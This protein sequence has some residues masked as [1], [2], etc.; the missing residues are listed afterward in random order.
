MARIKSG[1]D[2]L[3]NDPNDSGPDQGTPEEIAAFKAK[4]TSTTTAA[5]TTAPTTEKTPGTPD[6]GKLNDWLMNNQM[7]YGAGGGSMNEQAGP[8]GPEV[9][10][11][12][13]AANGYSEPGQAQTPQQTQ[14]QWGA[15][16]VPTA[17]PQGG[18]SFME[19]VD[20]GKM[21]D[22]NHTTPK[23][24][25]ARIL[26]SGGSLADAAK[27]IGATVLG[28]DTM[29]LATGETIDTRRDIEG[30]NQLQWLVTNDP[31]D[32][33]WG[34]P[35]AGAAGAAS[36]SLGSGSG[37]AGKLMDYIMGKAGQ[38]L[39][40][41]SKDPLIA[42]QVNAYGAAS[43]RASNDY[44]R[45]A[46]ERGGPVNNLNQEARMLAEKRGQGLGQFTGQL[47][48]QE[49]TTR[50]NEIMQAL[51]LGAAY[52]TDQQRLAL[53]RQ[54]ADMDNALAYARL[55]QSAYEFDSNDE[56]RRSP[57]AN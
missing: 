23:Y 5:P 17:M 30:A 37:P 35:A 33:N 15:N 52:M 47:M 34:K 26:A 41:N 44:L 32:P 18:Y 21:N 56:F 28:P 12:G 43:Q 1:P 19:G 27:A 8:A 48:Q 54:L 25:A 42:K 13:T 6:T 45:Q 2:G 16:G 14:S 3:Y 4:Q 24:V 50:R 55:G 49:L 11:F 9:N 53:Q 40:I 31:N 10:S 29:R 38:S 51:Q 39:D 7:D 57:L 22:A 36:G 46:A 20:S